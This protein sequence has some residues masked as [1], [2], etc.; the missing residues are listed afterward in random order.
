MENVFQQFKNQELEK[1]LGYQYLSKSHE[2]NE[3]LNQK[4]GPAAMGDSGQVSRIMVVDDQVFNIE[5][6]RC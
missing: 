2:S 5:F 6:L 3:E 1:T 4:I